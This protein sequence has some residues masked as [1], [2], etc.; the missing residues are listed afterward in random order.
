[1]AF[2]LAAPISISIFVQ[3]IATGVLARAMPQLNLLL[4][5]LPL[6]VGM[7]LFLFGFGAT[8]FVHAFKDILE[9]WPGHV[10]SLVQEA[11]HGG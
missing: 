1:M 2:Q 8:E 4:V 7:M 5:N 11:G 10:A 9:A 6:H 3:N